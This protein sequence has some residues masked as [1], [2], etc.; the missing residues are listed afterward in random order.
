MIS[1]YDRAGKPIGLVKAM[2]LFEDDK[3]RVLDW[4]MVAR[5]QKFVS[6]VWLGL[7]SFIGEGR[8]LFETMVF[9]RSGEDR[10]LACRRY[11]TEEEAYKGHKEMVRLWRR[12]RARRRALEREHWCQ[13]LPS[14]TY[15]V[16]SASTCELHV[17]IET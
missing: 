1:M 4:T 6:T 12:N 7:D 16:R 15:L 14:G 5:G 8:P 3:Y 13:P 9:K 17:S 11:K 10:T 2:E